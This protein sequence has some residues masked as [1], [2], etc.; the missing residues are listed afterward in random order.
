M[1]TVL[2]L[3]LCKPTQSA[4]N[5]S[6]HPSV[7]KFLL[8]LQKK[9]AS[10]NNIIMDGRDIGTVILPNA[11]LKIFLRIICFDIFVQIILRF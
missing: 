4:S 8:D 9:I 7:R 6:A 5:V 2:T 1:L 10:E 11:D 3:L